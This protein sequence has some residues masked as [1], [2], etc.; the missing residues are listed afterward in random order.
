MKKE[1]ILFIGL[2]IF[3]FLGAL[4]VPFFNEDNYIENVEYTL[5]DEY[6]DFCDVRYQ[7]SDKG[8]IAV[9][10]IDKDVKSVVI[11]SLYED[12]YSL[13]TGFIKD[14]PNLETI[15]INTSTYFENECISNCKNLKEIRLNYKTTLNTSLEKDAFVIEDNT[16]IVIDNIS[17]Y[18]EY[19]YSFES[20]KNHLRFKSDVYLYWSFDY[21]HP[22]VILEEYNQKIMDE[23]TYITIEGKVFGKKIIHGGLG[24]LNFDGFELLFTKDE[25]YFSKNKLEKT[26]LKFEYET[27]YNVCYVLGL[28]SNCESYKDSKSYT[29][30]SIKE[31]IDDDNI[32]FRMYLSYMEE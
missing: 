19:V 7:K 32:S 11:M 14:N 23:H 2:I 9:E 4:I 15:T 26:K 5:M 8:L 21:D 29:I 20:Y 13:A 25:M 17:C 31:D 30:T 12:I 1:I 28:L 10:L 16:S 24:D 6:V 27:S 3:I 18:E 22:R